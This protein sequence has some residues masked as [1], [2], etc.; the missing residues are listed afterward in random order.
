M[1]PET[2][3]RP[4]SRPGWVF[5]LKYDGFRVLSAGGAGEALAARVVGAWNCSDRHGGSLFGG[6]AA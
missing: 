2:S 4:F 5:E 6:G 3:A 1:K